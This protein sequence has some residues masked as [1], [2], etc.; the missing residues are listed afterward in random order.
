MVLPSMGEREQ[1][2]DAGKNPAVAGSIFLQHAPKGRLGRG[3]CFLC[4]CNGCPEPFDQKKKKFQVTAFR[5]LS[6]P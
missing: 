6:L 1:Q 5:K 4:A 3:I 2:Q